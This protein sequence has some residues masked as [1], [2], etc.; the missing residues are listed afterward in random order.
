M[1]PKLDSKL[2]LLQ[3]KPSKDGK[4]RFK[5]LPKWRSFAKSGHTAVLRFIKETNSR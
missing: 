3:N 5:V 1:F 4:K 2:C